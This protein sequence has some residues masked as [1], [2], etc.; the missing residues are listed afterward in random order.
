M[1]LAVHTGAQRTRQST[2]IRTPTHLSLPALHQQ[3]LLLC[4]II[5]VKPAIVIIV[6]RPCSGV[7]LRHGLL[8]RGGKGG[9]CV[10]GQGSAGMGNGLGQCSSHVSWLCARCRGPRKPGNTASFAQVKPDQPARTTLCRHYSRRR[11]MH[12]PPS[13]CQG[14][15]QHH[16]QLPASLLPSAHPPPQGSPAHHTPA[17]GTAGIK[18]ETSAQ[19]ATC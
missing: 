2:H 1:H 3:L 12:H 8:G 15:R 10:G 18:Q 7:V 6:I 17:W 5:S 4:V 11:L 14:R 19:A 16:R 13:H 9:E